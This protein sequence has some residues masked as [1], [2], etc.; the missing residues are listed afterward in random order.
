[1]IGTTNL[2][3]QR[4]VI[5]DMGQIAMLGTP[6]ALD[7]FRKVLLSSAAIP[8]VFPPGFIKVDAGGSLYDEM[9]VD[10]GVTREVFL[11]PT[12][13][14]AK[15]ADGLTGVNPVRRIFIIRNGRVAPEWKEVKARTLSIAGRSVSTLIKNQG[16]G[17]LYELFVFAK[18]NGADYNLAVIPETSPTPAPPPSIRN[19]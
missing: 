15:T 17:D 7:L 16:I 14:T 3:A 11:L 9:H 13:F 10:G 4:P 18:K 12:Q 19:T 6:E 1:M 5:W 2:D 8:A